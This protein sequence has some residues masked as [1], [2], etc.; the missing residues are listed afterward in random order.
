MNI[1]T[2]PDNAPQCMM[3]PHHF[4]LVY[5][6]VFTTLNYSDVLIIQE[7]GRKHSFYFLTL[8]ALSL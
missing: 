4:V 2:I 7:K 1:V 6:I 5:V 8:S 3:H